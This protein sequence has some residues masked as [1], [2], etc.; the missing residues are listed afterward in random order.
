MTTTFE[1]ASYDHDVVRLSVPAEPQ[2]FIGRLFAGGSGRRAEQEA[3]DSLVFAIGELRMLAETFPS[4]IEIDEVRIKLTHRVCASLTDAAAKVLGLPDPIPY[5]L[6]ADIEG[7]VGNSSFRLNTQ[8]MH[9]D[10]RIAHK[11]VG[12]FVETGAGEF[13]V[14]EPLYSAIESAESFDPATASLQEHWEA[15]AGFRGLL[16]SYDDGKDDRASRV[17]LTRILKRMKIH[18]AASFSLRLEHNG[19]FHPVLFS[20]DARDQALDGGE[21]SEVD[22]LLDHE[23]SNVFN[24]DMRRGFRS[25]RDAKSTYSLGENEYLIIEPTL[26]TALKVVREKQQASNEERRE[27]LKNP[28][29]AVSDAI[30]EELRSSG[31]LESHDDLQIEQAV[32]EIAGNLFFETPEYY[33]RAI[34]LGIWEKP[35]LSFIARQSSPWMPETFGIMIDDK[36]VPLTVE[37]TAALKDALEEGLS[38][39]QETVEFKGVEIGCT[40][41]NLDQVKRFVGSMEPEAGRGAGPPPD[42]DPRPETGEIIAAELAQNFEEIEFLQKIPKRPVI[43]ARRVPDPIKTQLLTYQSQGLS[44]FVDNWESGRGGCLN[45]DDQGCGKT[46]QT[47]SFIVWLKENARLGGGDLRKPT[48]VVAPTTLLKNWEQEAQKHL[49]DGALGAQI[50]AYGNHLKELRKSGTRGIDVDD[51]E[52]RLD[53]S[54]LLSAIEAGN[55]H[56]YW[57]LTTYRTLSNYQH[58]FREVPF[59]V[60]V[61]DEIQNIKNPKSF[62]FHS[63]RTLVADFRVGLTGTPIE[64]HIADLWSI[65]D[66]L[67]PGYLGSLR[68]FVDH[69][70]DI[71]EDKMR[72]LHDLVFKESGDMP[73]I[74]LRRMKEAVVENLPRKNYVI[75]RED[76]PAEQMKAY[77]TI[78]P[79]LSDAGKGNAIKLL[80][81]IRSVSLH[82]LR[83]DGITDGYD[84]FA[85]KSARLI[86]TLGI[87]QHI[88]ELNERALLFVEDHR[89]QWIMVELIKQ[90]FGLDVVRVINGKTSIPAR[91]R[92]VDEFQAKLESGDGFDV[93]VLGPKA[94]GVGLTLTAATHVIHLSRWWNPAVEE[95]C[96]DRI[97]RIGQTKDVFVHLPMAIHENYRECSFDCVLNN[98]L[99][100]KRQLSRSVLW[101]PLNDDFDIGQLFAGLTEVE[102]VSLPDIDNFDYLKF[103]HWIQQKMLETGEWE[104]SETPAWGDHGADGVFVNRTNRSQVVIPQAK[105]T[106]NPSTQ[107]GDDAV[108]G[109]LRSKGQYGSDHPQLVVLT[110]ARSFSAAAV[111]LARD[112]GV[113]LVP[114]SHLSLWPGHVLP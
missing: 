102:P 44:W 20:A 39:Q 78:R 63:A 89:M 43:A 113:T 70:K 32:A 76:M 71:T 54:D 83:S 81:H 52:T 28:R 64:N 2:S 79:L 42:G 74:G 17:R 23:A 51:G 105:H 19:D 82:P 61:F 14:S 33:D 3:N 100:R 22:A 77:D 73:P 41:D 66:T 111:K 80:H 38:K 53:F 15:L 8:W 50:R 27:F 94:A 91:M 60:V 108:R 45:A 110:N 88:K 114:R 16:T 25:S 62:N 65:V 92:Y 21:I 26:V 47:L 57:V 48:L 75:Y 96:N 40:E 31:D 67:E 5:I 37:E 36:W 13:R 29:K 35:K 85:E 112:E 30:E 24:N 69:H 56:E 49:A 34:G 93:M 11:R 10:S 104:V 46:I 106:K 7:V 58:S 86:A 97:Y 72:G 4:D 6:S 87:L 98:L 90:R 68:A 84:H 12:S 95:Q 59:S 109:V 18:T 101:P 9:G 99:K 1:L 103:E 55:G 107:I